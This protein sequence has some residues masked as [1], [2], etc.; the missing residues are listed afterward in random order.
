MRFDT[1]GLFWDDTPPPRILKPQ[2]PKRTPPPRTWEEPGYLPYLEEAR[3]LPINRF[4]PEELD[5]AQ[6]AR[7]I[8]ICDTEVYSNYFL[9]AF[10]SVETGKVVYFETINEGF[11]LLTRSRLR[12]VLENF[13]IVDFN[14]NDFDQPML[15]LACAGLA[16][17]QLKDASNRLISEEGT[18]PWMVLKA[19][20]VKPLKIDHIDL[21]EVAPLTA[22]LKIYGG[23][24]HVPRMQELPFKHTVELNAD[25]IAIVRWYCIGSD[26]TATAFLFM[27]LAPQIQLRTQ[28]SMKYGTD[29][30]SKSDAQIAE[31]VINAEFTRL[32]YQKPRRPEIEQG[33]SFQY[34]VPS[35]INFESE[36]LNAALATVA[37]ARFVIGENGAPELPEEIKALKIEFGG[38]VY[39]MGIG[40][41]HS[42]D[43]AAAH[44]A[45]DD[46]VLMD[47]D[48]TSYYPSI[49][50]N[51]ELY[52]QHLGRD[53]L[54]VYRTL[55][56]RRKQAK[57]DKNK[58]EADTIKIVVN[59]AFGKLGSKWS[60]LY[61]PDLLIQV[62]M[63]GQ[64]SL[65]ML[66]ERLYAFGCGAEICSANTDGVLFRYHKDKAD[67][68]AAVVKQ[69]EK[70]TGFET[71]D[72]PYQAVFARDVNNYIAV[73]KGGGF[74]VKG[75]YSERGSAGDSVLS[76]NPESLICNDAVVK[77]LTEGIPV[78]ETIYNCRDIRRFV[79]VRTVKG[80]AVKDGE[81]L[82]K[83]IRWYYSTEISGEIVYAL[84]G[85]KVPKS[86]NARPCME[87]PAEFP[88]DLNFAH[89]EREALAIL[90]EIGCPFEEAEQAA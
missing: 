26:L 83:A 71:E 82:G 61:A 15:A 38:R 36:V 35:Y 54:D 72:T 74:K 1:A 23:R 53:F 28:M 19:F 37:N 90:R 47:R 87:L 34:K 62:T 25:Q 3:R 12:W 16:T 69:W 65:L 81:Y 39:K 17:S 14:G 10:T 73:K 24:L 29:L 68:I 4:T 41:L 66:I 33:Q 5:A 75:A 45:D 43:A 70:E 52:P 44:Y 55:V 85:N 59:G 67:Y 89:Y 6:S 22:S 13:L 86:D 77:F 30:R 88:H 58:V 60:T 8:L 7:E 64:L 9:A 27:E 11:D 46:F 21:I 49:I 79:S 50:L 80:G 63:T 2:P 76:K 56:N 20:K 32:T 48:V 51:Q 31:A 57:K 18:K 78:A 40:G 84:T 42:E